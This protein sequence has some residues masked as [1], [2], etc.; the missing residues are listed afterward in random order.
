MTEN[1]NQRIAIT[2]DIS[3]NIVENNKYSQLSN[4]QKAQARG[5][6]SDIISG[7]SSAIGVMAEYTKLPGQTLVTGPLAIVEV[8]FSYLNYR[9]EQRATNQ[10]S[11]KRHQKILA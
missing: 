2:F 6:V 4:Q 10:N 3:G 7:Q 5:L 8:P 11:S 9:D 1:Q